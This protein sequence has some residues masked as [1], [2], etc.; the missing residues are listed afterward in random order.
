VA[1][2]VEELTKQGW[3]L[4]VYKDVILGDAANVSF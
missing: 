3:S 1:K 2:S 4:P